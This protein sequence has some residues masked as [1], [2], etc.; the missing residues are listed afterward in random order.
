MQQELYD[1]KVVP[2]NDVLFKCVV[3]DAGVIQYIII[4]KCNGRCDYAGEGYS[5]YCR[6]NSHE[7][8]DSDAAFVEHYWQLFFFT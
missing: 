4:N 6:Y 1:K 8:E 7:A 3:G 2:Y 5:D